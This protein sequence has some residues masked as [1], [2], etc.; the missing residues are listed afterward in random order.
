MVA[1]RGRGAIW[2]RSWPTN[3]Q[4]PVC[5]FG[6]VVIGR[7]TWTM[8]WN[9]SIIRPMVSNHWKPLKPMIKRLEKR[10]SMTM[11]TKSSQTIDICNGL[12]EKNY[13]QC[14]D[15]LIGNINYLRLFDKKGANVADFPAAVFLRPAQPVWIIWKSDWWIEEE[16]G[17]NLIWNQ[18][19]EDSQPKFKTNKKLNTCLAALNV[20]TLPGVLLV[21]ALVAMPEGAPLF[22]SWKFPSNFCTN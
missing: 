16:G 19:I 1:S 7:I 18:L 20:S 17:I 13:W 8:V 12:F 22:F 3:K 14:W 4:R 15:T 21:L 5:P 2:K 9:H 11:V 6:Q 10:N